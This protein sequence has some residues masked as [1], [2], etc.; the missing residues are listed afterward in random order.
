MRCGSTVCAYSRRGPS[1]PTLERGAGGPLLERL[2]R[3]VRLTPMGRA[4]LPHARAALAEAERART[5]ARRA[6]GP[7]PR[8]WDRPVGEL[9]QEEL[10]L[11][12]P[13]DHP[14]PDRVRLVGLADRS[15][16]HYA[17]GNGLAEVVDQACTAAGF[18]PRAAVRTEQAAAAPL[19]A[20][21][22]LGP[23]LA[24]ESIV[25]PGFASRVL[26]PDPPV[27]RMPTCARTPTRPPRH[28]WTPSP[29]TR[30]SRSP[31]GHG[32]VRPAGPPRT[33]RAV[34]QAGVR[35]AA[36]GA[37]GG[38]PWRRRPTAGAS[39]PRP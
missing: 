28:S 20:A 12:V 30:T 37:C 21:T 17:P 10:V 29:G 11:A 7:E 38:R 31:A 3:A 5:T 14:A 39:P 16:V 33:S 27:R 8:G 26:R 22:G 2:P 18:R 13:A 19:L 4:M 9:G 32:R 15:W 34:R 23:A 6:V 1:A 24:P 36:A 25:P 35:P